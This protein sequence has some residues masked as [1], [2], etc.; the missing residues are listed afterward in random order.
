MTVSSRLPVITSAI[1]LLL[2]A[3]TLGCNRLKARDQLN[4]GVQ[5]YKNARFEE[6]INHFQEAI[7]LDP[8]L[9]TAK[10][11]LATAYAQ[12]VVP[13]V[14]TPE[15]LK[16][17]NSAIALYQEV[18]DKDP[19]DMGSLKGIAALYLN[20]NKPD[21]AKQYQEKVLAIDPN[22][23]DANYTVGY[24]DWKAAYNNA[25][26]VRNKLGQQDDGSPIKDKAACAQLAAVNGPI[27][28]EGVETLSKAIQSRPD[29]SDA[30]AILNL[31]YRRKAE[32]ECGNDDARKAD[33]AKADG[34]VQKAMDAKK[35]EEAKKS[36]NA[37]GGI[38]IDPDK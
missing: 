13:N 6:A 21:Q 26:P 18:L 10:L 5:A 9:P 38:S 22:D 4:K 28:D 12:Q 31:T 36:S 30:M 2:L 29:Y 33:I 32:I 25:I 37:S 16:N 3:P 34:L 17:A 27:I 11:Y 8:S 24:I 14:T 23:A 19:K 20:I 7:N 1:L 15:N 35:S